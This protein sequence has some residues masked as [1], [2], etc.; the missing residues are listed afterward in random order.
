MKE[1]LT[2]NKKL[3]TSFFERNREN[4]YTIDMVLEELSS[5]GIDIAKSSLYR[6]VGNLCRSGLLKRYEADG[7]DSFVYQYSNFSSTCEM[8]FHLKCAKCGKLIH[9][10]CSQLNDIKKHIKEEHGFI[11]GGGNII[12]GTC[13]SCASQNKE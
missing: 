4:H 5:E 13:K 2:G 10:E 1:Y 9:L 3:V 7:V 8:H 11:I 6:I 12:Y